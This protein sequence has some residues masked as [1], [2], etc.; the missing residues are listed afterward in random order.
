[1]LNNSSYFHGFTKLLLDNTL[2]VRLYN[3]EAVSLPYLP[4]VARYIPVLS[5][6]QIGK[7]AAL[8][9]MCSGTRLFDNAAFVLIHLMDTFSKDFLDVN[10]LKS[11]GFQLWLFG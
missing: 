1:M 10:V 11:R 5:S 8:A 9:L 3:Y 4:K 2:F 7:S 6:C